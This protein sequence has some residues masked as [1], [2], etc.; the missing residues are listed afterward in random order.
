MNVYEAWQLGYTGSG[1]VAGVLDTGIEQEH[2]EFLNNY[3]R[4]GDLTSSF[5]RC[6][7]LIPALK[8]V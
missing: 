1:I 6:G 3:V 2:D 4:C 7:D 8:T 5:K